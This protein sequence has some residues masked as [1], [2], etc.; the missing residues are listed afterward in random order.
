MNK[1]RFI[2]EKIYNV[3]KYDIK[4]LLIFHNRYSII[5]IVTVVADKYLV[6][7]NVSAV[8]FGGVLLWK[9]Q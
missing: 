7:F 5:S 4:Y 1:I 2:Y 3:P 6:V 8:T 9:R